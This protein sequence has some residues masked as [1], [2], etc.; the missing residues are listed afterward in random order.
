MRH[1]KTGR[2]LHRKKDS[3]WLLKKN[4]MAD[5]ILRG[6]IRTTMAKAKETSKRIEKLITKAKK[7]D[8]HSLRELKR[9][10]PEKASD[11]LYYEIASLFKERHG[12]YTRIIKTG[13]KKVKDGSSLVILEFINVEEN[14]KGK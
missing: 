8:L 7:Q 11:K 4:L 6:R 2:K 14:E 10:L 3:R 5:L 12:G 13:E 1:L 9:F